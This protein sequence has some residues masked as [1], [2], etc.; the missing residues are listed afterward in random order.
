MAKHIAWD[1]SFKVGNPMIDSQHKRLFEIADELY[2]LTQASEER[3]EADTALVLQD[4]AKYVNFH[5]SC[6]EKLM[7][8]SHY[9]EI[10]AHISQHKAFTTYVVSLMSDFGRGT[11]IDLD[12]L[13]DFIADWLVQHI[14]TEDKKLANHAQN[15]GQ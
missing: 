2:S 3:K 10:E 7:H 12:K 15:L 14:S 6:E 8:D 11:K 5:F 4:C 9:G 13:Y 1:D